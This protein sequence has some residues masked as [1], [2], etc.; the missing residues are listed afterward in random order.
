MVE[1]KPLFIG[2]ASHPERDVRLA[3]GTL[4]GS[5]TT[6]MSRPGGVVPGLGGQL[7]TTQSAAPAMSVKVASGGLLIPGTASP[8]QGSYLETNDADKTL[9]IAASHGSL[10]RVDIVVFRVRDDDYGDPLI[11]IGGTLEVVTGVANAVR[12]VPATPA[13]AIKLYEI[14]VAA[15]VTTIL[16]ANCV[17]TRVWAVAPGGLH[18]CLSTARPANPFTG[19]KIFETNT[20]FELVWTGSAWRYVPFKPAS[21]QLTRS[22]NQVVAHNTVTALTLTVNTRVS[23]SL[24][25][26]APHSSI[27]IPAGLDGEYD[28][29]LWVPFSASTGGSTRVTQITV[30]AVIILEDRR[31]PN[32]A[33]FPTHNYLATH[34]FLNVGDV[35]VVNVY[36]DAGVSLNLAGNGFPRLGLKR[37]SEV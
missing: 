17:D 29:A 28:V 8:T 12:T 14:E 32:A 7:L 25:P 6:T 10:P 23:G 3:M 13:N 20:G 5:P 4:L 27:T 34:V 9:T 15:T 18:P 22:T 36:H 21:A 26:A 16:T 31:P 1:T 19:M 11:S 2:A 30:N 35:I 24:V 33:S 37:T